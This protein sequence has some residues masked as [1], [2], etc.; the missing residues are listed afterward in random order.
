MTKTWQDLSDVV[1]VCLKNMRSN[2]FLLIEYNGGS[3]LGPDPDA[4][5]APDDDNWHCEVVSGHY[6]LPGIWPLDELWLK[7]AGW[8]LR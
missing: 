8:T 2:Q 3:A 5:F 4:Q 7:R 6:L 1:A